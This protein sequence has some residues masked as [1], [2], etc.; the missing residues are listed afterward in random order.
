MKLPARERD[1]GLSD[2]APA[3]AAGCP[4]RKK[5]LVFIDWYL[6]GYR[7]GGPIQSVVNMAR[8]LPYDFWIITSS[9]DHQSAE[10][11]PGITTGQ[12]IC[13]HSNEHVMYLPP[14]GMTKNLLRAVLA[15]TKFD[16]FYINSIFSRD[17]A[18]KPLHYLRRRGL[19]TQVIIAP[20]GMLK[21]GALSVKR[22]KKHVFLTLARLA[23]LFDGVTWHAT[24][25]VEAGEIRRHFPKAQHIHVATNLPRATDVMPPKRVKRPGELRLVAV[26]R[27]SREKNIADG[28]GYLR[29][30]PAHVRA[31][32]DVFGPEQDLAYSALCREEAAKGP[33]LITFKGPVEPHEIPAILGDYDFFYLPTLGENYGHS[34][35]EALLSGVPVIVSDTTPWQRVEEARAGWALPLRRD[36]FAAVLAR[37]AAMSQQEHQEYRHNA[38]QLGRRIAEDPATTRAYELLFG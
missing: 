30:L 27:V 19:A 34:I 33:A 9:R 1:A 28:I 36:A 5:I 17:F 23:G 20:R 26:A 24:S 12:W 7:A 37:C 22:V 31:S 10:S 21:T 16:C 32:W 29:H 8:R 25:S 18:L 38:W 14:G 2:L 13:R 6:P 4:G 11:Y 35:A 3:A 15:S